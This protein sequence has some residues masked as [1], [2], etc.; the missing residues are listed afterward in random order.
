MFGSASQ[1]ASCICPRFAIEYDLSQIATDRGRSQRSSHFE[2]RLFKLLPWT[3][4]EL[5]A[6]PSAAGDAEPVEV[7][8]SPLPRPEFKL[9]DRLAELIKCRSLPALARVEKAPALQAFSLRQKEF[10]NLDHAPFQE[11]CVLLEMSP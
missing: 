3:W 1:T 2:Q 5:D 7:L 4:V 11:L 8:V 9:P 10:T 6:Q